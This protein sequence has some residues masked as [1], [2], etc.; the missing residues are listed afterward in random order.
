MVGLEKMSKV[1]INIPLPE[2]V[3]MQAGRNG[4]KIA[5]YFHKTSAVKKELTFSELDIRSNQLANMLID[6]GVKEGEFVG[7]CME[8]NEFMLIGLLAILKVGAAYVPMDPAY[9]SERLSYMAEIADI[10]LLLM[11]SNERDKLKSFEGKKYY[12]DDHWEEITDYSN[13]F[14]S[15]AAVDSVA[16]I[17]FTSGSTGKPKGVKIPH[18]AVSNFLLSMAK[19]PGFT[20][21]DTMLALTT[22]SFDIAVLEIYL[23]LICGGTVVVASQDELSDA[24]VLQQLIKQYNI[25]VVQA[26]PSTWR[27]LLNVGFAGGSSDSRVFKALCGGEKLTND[28]AQSLKACCDEV[29]NMY[30]PTETTV[31][32][33]CYRLP[34]GS[35]SI[36]IGRPI[37]ETHFFVLDEKGKKV[38]VGDQ[39][40][41][42]IG[43]MGVAQ[44]YLNRIDLTSE[45]FVPN[46]FGKGVLYRTGDVVEEMINGDFKYYCRIDDQVKVRGFRIELGEIESVLMLHENIDQAVVSVKNYSDKDQ[47]LIAYIQFIPGKSLTNGDVR[48]HLR[49]YLPDYMNPQ[50][51]VEVESFPL[52]PNGKVDRNS[53]PDPLEAV[54]TVGD[55]FPPETSTQKKIAEI[56]SK[57]LGIERV[58]LTDHFFDLG[59]HSLLA[60]IVSQDI[61]LL[62]EH[63]IQSIDLLSNSLEKLAEKIDREE[64][65]SL[66]QIANSIG[67]FR[68]LKKSFLEQ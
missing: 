54:N 4:K 37:D 66:Q 56:W 22:L 40:E 57:H 55:Y 38:K 33:S 36:L 20:D 51:L 35:D 11:T 1:N 47:R 41:L 21:K 28:L 68:S 14:T 25:N 59:G 43:G 48:K 12:V 27:N 60:I 29:W 2:L 15:L 53:L 34:R 58:G 8:R 32:S 50:F 19:R 16:Y 42:Y 39:G 5:A 67:W 65:D 13:D 24:I 45:R 6:Q 10:Q 52:T 23:P 49:D 63:S 64:S 26:T 62:Y 7:I 46:P 9:P 3:S 31:W 44:G 18:C 30:G 61:Q 17:I